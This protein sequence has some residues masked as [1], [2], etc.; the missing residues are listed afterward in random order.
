[1]EQLKTVPLN[2]GQQIA[3]DGFFEFLFS[4]DKE[5]CLSG[6][7]GSGK[8]YLMSYLIDEILPRYE[9]ACEMTGI[10]SQF[11][12]VVMT[13]TTNQAASVLAE[14]TRRPAETIYSHMS[15]VVR[16]NFETGATRLEQGKDWRIHTN[17]IIF[18]DEASYADGQLRR[19]ILEGTMNCKIVWV[20]DD[21]QLL[22]VGETRSAVFHASLPQFNLTE[23][24]RTNIPEL[25]AINEQLRETV[26]TSVFH[27]IQACPGI[28]DWY[29]AGQMELEINRTFLQQTHNARIL[30]YTNP[31]V[32]AYNDHIRDLRGLGADLTV[33]EF[34]VNNS[35]VQLRNH[36]MSVSEELE[37][38]RVGTDTEF[39]DVTD[40][41]ALEVRRMDLQNRYG[42]TYYDVKVPVDRNHYEQ[43]LKYFKNNKRWRT[44]Y[45]LKNGYPDLRQR[46]AATVHKAQGSS[47]GT[48][49]IDLEDLSVCRSPD[50]AA[51]L[52][53]VAFSRARSRVICYGELAKKFGGML[54]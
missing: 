25:Q 30:C 17:E 20:G 29:D 11:N 42:H 41:S 31:R 9:Q 47:V 43:L 46:D 22:G 19:L 21:R 4:K 15:I 16:E 2:Q 14:A 12:E 52:L 23:P 26:E 10:K 40:D 38:L 24:M 27:P 54:A 34:L 53:Y 33:G 39:V 36:T 45:Q 48:V 28:I 3:A 49:F 18:V 1:M 50:T 35:M 37:V 51:R 8:T 5:L 7:G 13:A 44:Y 6:P 32:L